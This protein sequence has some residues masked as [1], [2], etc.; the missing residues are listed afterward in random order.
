MLLYLFFALSLGEYYSKQFIDGRGNGI[1]LTTTNSDSFPAI[2]QSFNEKGW[3]ISEKRISFQKFTTES[4]VCS[5]D[6]PF[7]AGSW[8]LYYNGRFPDSFITIIQEH[9]C[10]LIFIH[11]VVFWVMIALLALFFGFILTLITCFI[12]K[13]CEKEKEEN[14]LK[15]DPF[16]TYQGYP[17]NE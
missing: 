11:T 15:Y 6:L 7:F 12:A 2:I 10:D 9:S 5:N 3:I 13:K 16:K 8:A 17:I 14:I 4:F 1:Y